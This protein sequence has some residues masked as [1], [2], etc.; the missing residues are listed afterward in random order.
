[1][2][3]DSYIDKREV[4]FY[5]L[6]YQA[7]ENTGEATPIRNVIAENM[8]CKQNNPPPTGSGNTAG[9]KEDQGAGL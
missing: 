9:S 5:K 4:A 7:D 2:H 1:M 6:N 3:P 8:Q